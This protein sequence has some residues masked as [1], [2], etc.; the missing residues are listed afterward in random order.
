M[1]IQFRPPLT[2]S[3][4]SCWISGSRSNACRKVRWQIIGFN[5]K[6]GLKSGNRRKTCPC[7]PT[8][9]PSSWVVHCHVIASCQCLVG[10]LLPYPEESW[11]IWD[12]CVGDLRPWHMAEK[13]ST[14]CRKA[15][16]CA[17]KSAHHLK[18][19]KRHIIP[20]QVA[21]CQSHSPKI[22]WLESGKEKET[23]PTTTT[24][25]LHIVFPKLILASNHQHNTYTSPIRNAI[26]IQVFLYI[27]ITH[28]N[29]NIKITQDHP[30]APSSNPKAPG[31]CPPPWP[32]GR[33]SA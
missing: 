25:M 23:P 31:L 33:A 26:Q 4:W 20:L 5:E 1:D 30:M 15:E 32:R 29:Q 18:N 12:I 21:A 16:P 19:Q 2:R 6:P 7:I 14:T 22:V 8:L 3:A 27:N 9:F 17:P 11:M 28:K 13:D 24:L 10:S